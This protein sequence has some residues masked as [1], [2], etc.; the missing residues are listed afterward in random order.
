MTAPS[1]GLIASIAVLN[2]TPTAFIAIARKSAINCSLLMNEKLPPKK[3][4]PPHPAESRGGS[5]DMIVMFLIGPRTPM[6]PPAQPF[7]SVV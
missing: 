2:A 5:K 4:M 7:L 3:S 6:P 1:M